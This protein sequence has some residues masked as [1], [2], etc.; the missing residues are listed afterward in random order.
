MIDPELLQR[1]YQTA[2]RDLLAQRN[3]QG[4]WVGELSSSA[5]STATAIST[6][7]LAQRE[8]EQVESSD[9]NF[10]LLNTNG[11]HWLLQEQNKDGGWGDTDKSLSNIATTMLCV[12]AL[13]L[14]GRSGLENGALERAERYIEEQ[15]GVSGLLSRYGRDKTFAVPILTNCALAGMVNWDQISALPFE[16]A[17]LP[18]SWYRF[19]GL[20]VV[21]Y[22]IPALVAVG[23]ARFHHLPPRN[24]GFR[25]VRQAAIQRTLSVLERTQPTSG[26]YLEA[27]PLTSFV[28]MSLIS[29]GRLEHPVVQQGLRFLID[30][31]RPDGSWPIDTN[32]AAW[33]TTLAMNALPV[34][35]SLDSISE[36]DSDSLFSCVDWLLSCQHRVRH[37]FTAADPGGWGWTDLSGAVPDA[38]DTA[39][40]LLALSSV[41]RLLC[42]ADEQRD[43]RVFR[44]KQNTEEA[45]ASGIEWLLKLQNVD[46]GWPTFCRGWG[47]L[48]FDRSGSDLTAHVMR[49]L[50]AHQNQ[51][52]RRKRLNRA[53]TR[54]LCYLEREQDQEGCW[55]PLWFGNQHHPREE[56]PL[57][58]TAKVLL[59]YR[60]LQRL[61][62]VPPQRGFEWLNSVQNSDGGWG[63]NATW[64]SGQIGI[65]SVE[66]TALA[67][68]A[69]IS[70]GRRP[71]LQPAIK[72]GLH[73]LITA[74]LENRH[75]ESSPI[76]FYFAKLWYYERLYP[77]VFTVAALGSAV[78]EMTCDPVLCQAMTGESSM[79]PS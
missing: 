5:L 47:K 16:L 14:A 76:G 73:W 63:G 37:P 68:E 12:A 43:R 17:C 51:F 48:P 58:G 20:P 67:V 45:I 30:S 3:A 52:S 42:C 57:Y 41:K 66:E 74:V 77:L 33:N 29:T 23:Q 40:A 53:L 78:R 54:G 22:A 35:K 62:M 61:E 71:S 18:H 38:D 34:S 28:T 46:G 4:H 24:P 79:T 64:G 31:V 26:G 36:K 59:A 11:V 8:F 32:L 2:C 39:G 13:K 9:S 15:G 70:G 21:S 44:M 56:N 7:C 49:A 10:E 25:W 1:A 60:D 65:S 55:A 50:V 75:Q 6:L 72:K 27:V 69:L 19:L